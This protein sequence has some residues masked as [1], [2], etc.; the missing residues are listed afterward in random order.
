MDNR[1]DRA[2]VIREHVREAERFRERLLAPHES[3]V[4]T[5]VEALCPNCGRI[6]SAR[7]CG[8]CGS[9]MDEALQLWREALLSSGSE[10]RNLPSQATFP[11]FDGERDRLASTLEASIQHI[12]AAHL[13]EQQAASAGTSPRAPSTAQLEALV[14]RLEPP[15]VSS[16]V[17]ADECPICLRDLHYADDDEVIEDVVV[18]QCRHGYHRACLKTWWMGGGANPAPL[19]AVCKQKV[20]W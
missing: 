5:V 16:G 3:V 9:S 11:G 20:P 17:A 12:Q 19:C 15:T 10:A 6:G 4:P 1:T 7:V 13:E 18:L 2:A 14:A 8:S